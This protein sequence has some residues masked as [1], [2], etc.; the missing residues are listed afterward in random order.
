MANPL[1]DKE[2]PDILND[3]TTEK[4]APARKGE[5]TV[6]KTFRCDWDMWLLKKFN[7]VKQL[8]KKK[9]E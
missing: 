3:F 7:K 6:S 5:M 8:F 1:S 9:E 4:Y 2:K